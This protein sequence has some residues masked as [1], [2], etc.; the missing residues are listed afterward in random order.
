MTAKIK[1]KI[2]DVWDYVCQNDYL[3]TILNEKG[4]S[5]KI[6]SRIVRD[7]L[8]RDFWERYHRD[9]FRKPTISIAR[10]IVRKWREG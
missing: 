3:N 8:V 5:V 1:I 6:D 10:E 2:E 4:S 9:E 7:Q